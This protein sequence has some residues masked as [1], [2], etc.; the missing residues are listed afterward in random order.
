MKSRKLRIADLMWLVVAAAVFLWAYR[1]GPGAG[2]LLLAFAAVWCLHVL[3]RP[4]EL[5]AMKWLMAARAAELDIPWDDAGRRGEAA[6]EVAGMY[7]LVICQFPD[8]MAAT[9]ARGR[10]ASLGYREAIPRRLRSGRPPDLP[11][12]YHRRVTS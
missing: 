12:S 11:E 7:L 6:A 8:S 3:S 4:R 1:S 2:G 5:H 10:I 9:A